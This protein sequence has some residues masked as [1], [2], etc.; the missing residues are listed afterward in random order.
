VT[1]DHVT[2]GYATT[3]EARDRLRDMRDR[4][5]AWLLERVADDGRPAFAD[6][7]HGYYRFPWTLAYVGEREAASAVMAWIEH[8][9]LTDDGD[10]REGV[11]RAAWV[12]GAAT[13][14]LTL[15]AQGAWLLER[16]GTA[17]AVM[18]TLRRNFQD[19][20][21]GGAYSE[22]PEARTTGYQLSF[23]TA[24]L[25]LTSL[26]TGQTDMA[27][28]VF[29]WY[30]RLMAAQP[31]LPSKLYPMWG[32]SGLVTEFPESY[33]F[34]ALVDFEKPLQTFHNPGIAASFLARYALRNGNAAAQRLSG[35][36]L[37]LNEN[38]T[39]DQFNHWEST[40]ICK[41][42]WGSAMLLDVG[43]D[44]RLVRNILRMTQWYAD[45]QNAD[46]SWVHRTPSRPNPTE[47]HVME[48]TVEHVQWVSMML[49][50]L[51]AYD[52][53]ALAEGTNQQELTT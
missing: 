40:S 37:A 23:A 12:S 35:E 11:A 51:A 2:T 39:P 47:A 20:E 16:Y 17:L 22:R 9:T 44:P 38:G 24:Q 48:K 28:A 5:V 30:E 3:G 32:P 26:T 45:S 43:P 21:T 6:E 7:H 29:G 1:V 19:P 42:G 50:S 36:F 46:G 49:T 13:Y 18:D 53:A 41:F 4:A 25:G 8:N 14:P 15:I 52:A 27:D 31:D 34:N 33:R 10:L